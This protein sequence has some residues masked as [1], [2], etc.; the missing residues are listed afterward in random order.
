MRTSPRP[1]LGTGR[2]SERNRAFASTTTM[3]F[4]APNRTCA[5]RPKEDTPLG[6]V[7]RLHPLP[8]AMPRTAPVL[9]GITGSRDTHDTDGGPD[10]RRVAH[11]ERRTVE[12]STILVLLAVALVAAPAPATAV[13]PPCPGRRFLV[14]PELVPNAG[15]PLDAIVVGADGMASIESGCAPAKVRVGRRGNRTTL[16]ARWAAC[17]TLR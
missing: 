10:G 8:P 9:R 2:S 6:A 12:T 13:S 11:R 1:G 15:M 16:R 7:R 3:V 17:G 5:A 4:M 14:A